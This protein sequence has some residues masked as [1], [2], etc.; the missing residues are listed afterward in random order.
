M[1]TLR[2]IGEFVGIPQDSPEFGTPSPIGLRLV[3]Q[4]LAPVTD[5]AQRSSMRRISERLDTLVPVE[6]DAELLNPTGR[7]PHKPVFRVK[8]HLPGALSRPAS[9]TAR[10][11]RSRRSVTTTGAPQAA[12]SAPFIS[13][14]LWDLEVRRTGIGSGG[15]VRLSKSFRATVIG[16]AVAS[17]S[18][19]A[20]GAA[21]IAVT[22]SGPP[23][24]VVFDV[25]GSSSSS[26]ASPRGRRA[27]RC[28]SSTVWILRAG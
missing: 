24:A 20:A 6:L 2:E 12:T 10:M 15:Y 19:T 28:G 7:E 25:T 4:L 13:P 26:P 16:H 9:F 17:N 14:G 21:V 18:A 27:S 8:G 5:L 3:G 23:N 22:H 11:V 1:R